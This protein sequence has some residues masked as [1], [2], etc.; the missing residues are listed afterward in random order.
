M[1]LVNNGEKWKKD[2]ELT[3]N[4]KIVKPAANNGSDANVCAKPKINA[5]QP[6]LDGHMRPFSAVNRTFFGTDD[7]WPINP[8]LLNFQYIKIVLH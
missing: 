3:N 4:F 8:S 1:S 6:V 2:L 5:Y 7:N